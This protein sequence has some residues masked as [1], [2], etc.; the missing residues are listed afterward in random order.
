MYYKYLDKASNYLE[1]GTGGS[2]YQAAVRQNI[3][4]VTSVESDKDWCNKLKE[5]LEKYKNKNINIIYCEMKTRKNNWGYPGHTSNINDWKN[6][7]D[8]FVKMEKLLINF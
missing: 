2:T 8:Q 4:T 5:K 6:Y 1:Y 3:K 7:S